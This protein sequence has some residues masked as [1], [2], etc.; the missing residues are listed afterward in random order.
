[1]VNDFQAI[2]LPFFVTGDLSRAKADT[3]QTAL[4]RV[5]APPPLDHSPF[6]E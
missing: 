2:L 4:Q 3:S 1:M 5:F 6:A